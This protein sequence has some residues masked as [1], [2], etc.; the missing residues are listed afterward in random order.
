MVMEQLI[1]AKFMKLLTWLSCEIY[2]LFLVARVS[3]SYACVVLLS[4]LTIRNSRQ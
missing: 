4:V 2:Q 3:P 1:K